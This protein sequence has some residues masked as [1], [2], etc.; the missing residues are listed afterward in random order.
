MT[1]YIS[2]LCASFVVMLAAGCATPNMPFDARAASAE[3][4]RAMAADRSADAACS[5]VVGPWGTGTV[6]WVKVDK[7]SLPAG[8]SVEIGADCVTKIEGSRQ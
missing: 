3:Q 6:V 8:T 4:I 5:K 1:R 7:S 2:P